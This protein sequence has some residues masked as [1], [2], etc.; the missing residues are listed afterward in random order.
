MPRS[1]VSGAPARELGTFQF[2]PSGNGRET[3]PYLAISSPYDVCI[4][5]SFR[6]LV[7]EPYS[8]WDTDIGKQPQAGARFR[9]IINLAIDDIYAR[10]IENKP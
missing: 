8:D 9:A 3:Y 7:K 6:N 1:I 2:T 4:R 10:Q 5:Q